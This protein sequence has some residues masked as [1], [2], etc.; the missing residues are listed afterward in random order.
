MH[1]KYKKTVEKMTDKEL[2]K[3]MEALMRMQLETIKHIEEVKEKI[4]I[5]IQKQISNH[6][7]HHG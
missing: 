5:V 6:H 1:N 4:S 2:M 7:K 3:E